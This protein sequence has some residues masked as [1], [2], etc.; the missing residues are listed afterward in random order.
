MA[1]VVFVKAIFLCLNLKPDDDFLPYNMPEPFNKTE[2]G[3]TDI[4]IA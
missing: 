2:H 3:P 4:V 1:G